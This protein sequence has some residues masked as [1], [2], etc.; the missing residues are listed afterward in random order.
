MYST[1]FFIYLLQ[2]T[3]LFEVDIIFLLWV[4]DLGLRKRKSPAEGHTAGRRRDKF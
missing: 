1:T 2:A 3:L 4:S